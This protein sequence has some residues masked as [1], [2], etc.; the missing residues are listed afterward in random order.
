MLTWVIWHASNHDHLFI[1]AMKRGKAR[2]SVI[3][4]DIVIIS[5]YHI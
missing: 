5:N 2:P 4:L 3:N 1:L